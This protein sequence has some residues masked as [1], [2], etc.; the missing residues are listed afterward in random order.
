MPSVKPK[1][2]NK[3]AKVSCADTLP[4]PQLRFSELIKDV[5][6]VVQYLDPMQTQVYHTLLATATGQPACSTLTPD[7]IAVGA[8][9]PRRYVRRILGLLI[10]INL[11]SPMPPRGW[12]LHYALTRQT[13]ERPARCHDAV[14]RWQEMDAGNLVPVAA[15]AKRRKAGAA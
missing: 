5:R 12:R 10:A 13:H 15:R 1:V 4:P 9:V 8:Q 6:E 2:K 3:R 7:E 14:Q 11:V